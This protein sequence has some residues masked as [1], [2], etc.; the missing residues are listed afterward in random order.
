MGVAEIFHAIAGRRLALSLTDEVS[1]ASAE[2]SLI[3]YASLSDRAARLPGFAAARDAAAGTRRG[4]RDYH[5]SPR[6]S[7]S[8]SVRPDC[9]EAGPP[10]ASP[11]SAYLP[12][13]ISTLQS[14]ATRLIWSKCS[15]LFD[16]YIFSVL[17]LQRWP[18]Y[19]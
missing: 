1:A 14:F 9:L 16:Y 17:R 10:R 5:I 3:F 18:E 15:M 11:G 6:A 12:C 2:A 8:S 19:H 7:L 13:L 4:S